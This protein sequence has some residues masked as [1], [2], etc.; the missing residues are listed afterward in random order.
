MNSGLWILGPGSFPLPSHCLTHTPHPQPPPYSPE[1][2]FTGKWGLCSGLSRGRRR[3][4]DVG[5]ALNH[6]PS[7][8]EC[9]GFPWDLQSLLPTGAPGGYCPPSLSSLLSSEFTHYLPIF[10]LPQKPTPCSSS[11]TREANEA[12]VTLNVQLFPEGNGEP[13]KG[14]EQRGTGFN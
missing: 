8:G 10:A 6:T 5:T 4:Q 3:H 7:S 11:G 13:R 12:H 9:Q 1:R 14:V 2:N